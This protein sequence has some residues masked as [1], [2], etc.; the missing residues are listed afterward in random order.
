MTQQ[1]KNWLRTHSAVEACSVASARQQLPSIEL[2]LEV[3]SFVHSTLS[4]VMCE[5]APTC[6]FA[7]STSGTA[8]DEH[9]PLVK[10]QVG[11][12]NMGEATHH[13]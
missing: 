12:R 6:C 10:S 8:H 2:A 3:Q 4:K 11:A 9:C 1:C 13:L 7:F 5:L